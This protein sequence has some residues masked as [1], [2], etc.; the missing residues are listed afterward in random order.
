MKKIYIATDYNNE[1][2]ALVLA[3]NYDFAEVAFQSMQILHHSIEE[4]DLENPDLEMV[5][6]GYILTSKKVNFPSMPDLGSSYREW[7]RGL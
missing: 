4:I 5:K 6:V 1:P 7:K 2:L 3:D